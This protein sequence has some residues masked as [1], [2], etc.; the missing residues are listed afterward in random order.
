MMIINW[1][2]IILFYFPKA[3]IFALDINFM[4]VNFYFIYFW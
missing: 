4:K 1:L 2:I 3:I